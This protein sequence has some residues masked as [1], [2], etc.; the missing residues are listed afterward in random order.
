MTDRRAH[1]DQA[2]VLPLV[3]ITVGDKDGEFDALSE[4]LELAA[5]GKR[6]R[7]QS[8]IVAKPEMP[9]T[10]YSVLMGRVGSL[11]HVH[12]RRLGDTECEVRRHETGTF[13]ASKLNGRSG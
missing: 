4:H 6:P 8:L 2:A 12:L 10:M 3:L 5:R 1:D 7:Y 13:L 11:E 9:D